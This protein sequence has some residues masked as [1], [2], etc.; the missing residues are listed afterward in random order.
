MEN[1]YALTAAWWC[2]GEKLGRVSAMSY[3]GFWCPS[4]TSGSGHL[5][6]P[7]ADHRD[8]KT[9]DHENPLV[10]YTPPT[11]CAYPNMEDSPFLAK[12]ACQHWMLFPL[13][14]Q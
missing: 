12:Q 7:G 10:I 6:D 8:F 1:R 11:F 9:Q 14:C 3:Y 2:M 4:M 13:S 5:P